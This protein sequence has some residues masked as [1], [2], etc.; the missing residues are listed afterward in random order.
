MPK[1]STLPKRGRPP[2]HI[3]FG[4]PLWAEPG[5]S[6]REFSNRISSTIRTLH[7]EHAE[8]AGLP[9]MSDYEQAAIA[10]EAVGPT[11]AESTEPNTDAAEG[12]GGREKESDE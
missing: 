3:V 5:E 12:S 1:G 7:D 2:V 11:A 10:A 6:A 9:L 4:D 8:Q